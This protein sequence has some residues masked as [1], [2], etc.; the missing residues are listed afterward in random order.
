KFDVLIEPVALAMRR[1]DPKYAPV[2]YYLALLKARTRKP[3]QAVPLFQAALT[4]QAD[5][6]KRQDY[7]REFLKAMA[8]AGPAVE[9]YQ[10]LPDSRAAFRD[11]AAEILKSYRRDQLSRLVS[12]HGKKHPDDPLLPLYQAEVYVWEGRYPLAEKT[13]AAALAKQLDESTLQPF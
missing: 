4:R 6:A 1:V 8:A 3:D 7:T 11:L 10:A 13:F 12:L 2:D 9:A 5:A